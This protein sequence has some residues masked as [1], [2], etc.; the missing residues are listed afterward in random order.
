MA[1]DPQQSKASAEVSSGKIVKLKSGVKVDIEAK[2]HSGQ[3]TAVRFKGEGSWAIITVGGV[4][5]VGTFPELMMGA[6]YQMEGVFEENKKY[7]TWNFKAKQYSV[8]VDTT[9]GIK[10]LLLTECPGLGPALANRLVT[11]F[12]KETLKLIEK[13]PKAISEFL[14]I[15]LDLAM[16]MQGWAAG[17]SA[18]LDI[19]QRLYRIGITQG[20]VSKLIAAYGNN[21]EQKIKKDCFGMTKIKGFGFKTV[22]QIA[23]LIG[24]PPDD[25]GR[26]KAAL[27]YSIETLYNEGHVCIPCT[28]II[29]EA[30]SLTGIVQQKVTPILE[31]MIKEKSIVTELEDWDKYKETLSDKL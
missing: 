11:R 24:V 7:N 5:C 23:D 1:S 14:G 2:T 12:Q 20:Q 10:H 22:A 16:K 3:L 31:E 28:E 8:E 18:N 6:T 27:L 25:P 30:C 15:S 17:Q 26:L 9:I 19:K 13:E 29:R 21:A 4:D